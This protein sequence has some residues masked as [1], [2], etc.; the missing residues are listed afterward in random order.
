MKYMY[1]THLHTCQSSACGWTKGRDYVPYYQ[2]MGYAGII[3]TDHFFRGNTA[4]KKHLPW[5]E[6]VNQFCIGYEDA[7]EAGEKAG[8]S[9]FFGWEE[10]YQG[11]EYLIY[12]LDK[13]WLLTH[14][15]AERYTRWQQFDAVHKAGGCVVQ[16]HPFRDREYL[17]A[18]HL[19]TG[20]V[21]AVEGYNAGND[22]NHDILAVHYAK[23]LGLPVT[24]GSD[25]HQIN[26]RP[27]ELLMGV[28]FDQPLNS[29]HDY[30]KAIREKQPFGVH[31][32]QG[33][34]EWREGVEIRLPVDIR[35]EI[36]VSTG[37]D[38]RAF[39]GI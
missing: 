7:R 9:V 20:C 35:D 3:V 25:M 5:H 28:V 30:V 38:I 12:G 26:H 10:N 6:R 18:I 32:P 31:I 16:A 36:D 39:L 2:D 14:P 17:S 13:Q 15:E 29:I 24:A 11:D 33:R 37:G 23:L 27:D 34:G 4:V 21:D 19:S 1:E 22:L 8:F